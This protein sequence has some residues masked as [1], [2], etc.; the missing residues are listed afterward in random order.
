MDAELKAQC[1]R[2]DENG[3]QCETLVP[4][5]QKEFYHGDPSIYGN[6]ADNTGW[7]VVHLCDEH[8]FIAHLARITERSKKK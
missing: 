1:Q 7:V 8:Q 4:A 6:D 5:Y 2:L 3:K